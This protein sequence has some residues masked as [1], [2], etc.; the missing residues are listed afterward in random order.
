MEVAATDLE[1][2]MGA[3]ASA[4]RRMWTSASRMTDDNCRAPSLLPGWSR[5][6]V[7]THWARNA[8]GQTRMLLAAMRGEVAAQYPGG[9]AEREADIETGAARPFPLILHDVRA[10]V[11]RVEDAWRR[12]PPA[13]WSRPTGARVG[14]RPA[15]KSV[16]ARWR[17]TEIHHVDLDADY[18]HDHWPAE[19]VTLMLPRVLP[20]LDSSAC[21]WPGMGRLCGISKAGSRARLDSPLTAEGAR[22]VRRNAVVVRGERVDALFSS[23]LGRALTSAAAF[24]A[25]LGMPV[26]VLDELSEVDHG[27]LSGLT[28]AEIAAAWPGQAEARAR[29]KYLYRFPRGESY[30]DADVRAGRALARIARS[31]ARAPLLVSHE[32]I[33]R[34]LLKNLAGLDPG[35]ALGRT[36]PWD[37]VY[38]VR[39]APGTI[40]V[41]TPGADRSDPGAL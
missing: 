4:H 34:M 24:A 5:G 1:E 6:H 27:E 32:M 25:T 37:V 14:Q 33:G 9:D 26:T 17:E 23:P 41:L 8:D 40:E 18:T 7:L 19:F 36:H 35:A 13:A 29:D 3:A 10:A 22:Q 15:W 31:G 38:K 28:R 20:T 16:W 21:T 2:L 12:M 39:P 11:D 30:A